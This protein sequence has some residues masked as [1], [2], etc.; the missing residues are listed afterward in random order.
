MEEVIME[1]IAGVLTP[2]TRTYEQAVQDAR[3]ERTFLEARDLLLRTDLSA[4]LSKTGLTL[5]SIGRVLFRDESFWDI[6]THKGR[7]EALSLFVPTE[8]S[9]VFSWTLAIPIA[10]V[11][12]AKDLVVFLQ[13]V[14]DKIEEKLSSL[15]DNPTSGRDMKLCLG[16]V[17][18]EANYHFTVL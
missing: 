17:V 7:L 1:L 5:G 16:F 14:L 4:F 6:R 12:I 9:K 18:T 15:D 2:Q 10:K 3:H 8:T 13:L 11:V